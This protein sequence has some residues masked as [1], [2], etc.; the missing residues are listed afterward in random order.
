M[1]R[2][3]NQDA[4]RRALNLPTRTCLLILRTLA[5]NLGNLTGAGRHLTI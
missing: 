4:T 2:P 3:S 5:A 1:K